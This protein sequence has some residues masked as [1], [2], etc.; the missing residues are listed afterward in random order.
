[1]HS[2]GKVLDS[3]KADTPPNTFMRRNKVIMRTQWDEQG[4]TTKELKT[5]DWQPVQ[6]KGVTGK[7][8]SSKVGILKCMSNAN[9]PQKGERYTTS[10]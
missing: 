10:F 5:T 2:Q 8:P 1:M 7:A 9:Q 4:H 3:V 6:P